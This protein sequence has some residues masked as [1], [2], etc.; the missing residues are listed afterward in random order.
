MST[1]I[2]LCITNSETFHALRYRSRNTCF[3]VLDHQT[4]FGC[5]D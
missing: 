2:K 5:S 1:S 4:L 3:R